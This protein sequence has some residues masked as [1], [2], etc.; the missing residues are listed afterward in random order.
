MSVL[1]LLQWN[2]RGT[3]KKATPQSTEQSRLEVLDDLLKVYQPSLICIQEPFRSIV[4][5]LQSGGYELQLGNA[6]NILTAFR[7]G[8]W[9]SVAPLPML[10]NK[11][12]MLTLLDSVFGSAR[13]AVWN[14]HLTSRFR[15]QDAS[16]AK[17]L[18]EELYI[19]NICPW[20]DRAE[21]A[22]RSEILSGDFNLSPY[23]KEFWSIRANRSLHWLR[24]KRRT[25]T[26]ERQL[27]NTSWCLLR[28]ARGPA[29]TYY[30]ESEH[31]EPWYVYDQTL[32]SPELGVDAEPEIVLEIKGR[33]LHRG[34]HFILD[35]DV[36]SDHYPVV[37]PFMVS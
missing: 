28:G 17:M 20:R 21:Y 8:V 12:Y 26:L 34:S 11:N 14:V 27:F 5:P 31:D 23:I 3:S 19:G 16:I 10:D 13:L 29:G 30:Y 37:V 18:Y 22:G 25:S 1:K 4:G 7:S 32:L 36:G 6:G 9:L 15:R 33:K 2:L 35:V 24:R